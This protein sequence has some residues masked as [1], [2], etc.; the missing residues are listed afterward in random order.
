MAAPVGLALADAA[1]GALLAAED[2]DALALERAEEMEPLTLEALEEALL[3]ALP[4][5]VAMAAPDVL[6]P[7]A[8]EVAVLLLAP[9]VQVAEAGYVEGDGQQVQGLFGDCIVVRSIRERTKTD[10]WPTGSQMLWAYANAA[11]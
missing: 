7:E 3:T 11:A 2:A 10:D 8:V 6:E 5:V 1:D 4:V 9:E